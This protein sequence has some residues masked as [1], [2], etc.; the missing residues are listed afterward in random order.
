[1]R[2]DNPLMERK[3]DYL[4]VEQL[5]AA[6]LTW[7]QIADIVG[8][9]T[10]KDMQRNH[11]QWLRG[12]ANR[13][14]DEDV[15]PKPPRKNMPVVG[16]VKRDM[17]AEGG[18]TVVLVPNEPKNLSDHIADYGMDLDVWQAE[19]IITNN[20]N[21]WCVLEGKPVVADLYQIKVTW[22]KRQSVETA[23]DVISSVLETAKKK[24]PKFHGRKPAKIGPGVLALNIPD[25][26]LGKLSWAP[27]TGVNYDIRIA[28]ETFG[29]AVY[30]LAS[31]ALDLN[32]GVI[33][34][35]IGNDF[36]NSDGPNNGKGAYTARGTQQDEDGRWQK[37]FKA[38]LNVILT[39]I[40]H[41]AEM[42]PKAKV[43]VDIVPGNHDP[44]RIFYLGLALEL[45]FA[46]HKR[47]EINAEP[48]VRKFF[49]GL[50]HGGTPVAIMMMHGDKVKPASWVGL[51]AKQFD[52]R[53]YET[54][55]IF[56]GH[57]HHQRGSRFDTYIEQDEILARQF[58]SLSPADSWH[59][60]EGYC[61]SQRAAQAVFYRSD[62][63]V[64]NIL[65][66]YPV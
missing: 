14:T 2:Q 34:L 60:Q 3:Y 44:E 65:H 10:G 62:G 48:T 64:G 59:D 7:T 26:H 57:L 11:S 12:R 63:K 35:P 9:K 50:E 19:R 58:P 49:D 29:D 27:E 55:E 37:S 6:G 13:R 30:D 53:Q 15:S 1:M 39:R 56:T 5:R 54:R 20:W 41:V 45:H 23:K 40:A 42:Y 52:L 33:L 25:L 17:T 22:K 38:G 21:G 18:S 32:P 36:L 66:H 46:N 61:L 31:Q 51:M 24:A 43:V 16:R 28:C 4:K 8:C 47:I